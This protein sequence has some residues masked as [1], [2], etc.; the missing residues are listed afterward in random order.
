MTITWKVAPEVY[1]HV[2]VTEHEKRGGE[3]DLGKK[4]E[5]DKQMYSSL[6]EVRSRSVPLRAARRRAALCV[7]RAVLTHSLS[8]SLA[9]SLALSLCLS[10]SLSLSDS[11]VPPSP[12]SS[13]A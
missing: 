2:R 10:L 5:V 1:D 8:L 7:V 4:L 11:S 12:S 6:D 13:T 9:L 3:L